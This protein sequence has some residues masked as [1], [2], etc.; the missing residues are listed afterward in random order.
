MTS[1]QWHATPSE[2]FSYIY[3][4]GERIILAGWLLRLFYDCGFEERVSW[5]RLTEK[6][7]TLSC[8]FGLQTKGSGFRSEGIDREGGA[9]LDYFL[10]DLQKKIRE[11]GRRISPA[12]NERS[13]IPKASDILKSEIL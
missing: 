1:C 7:A 8:N 11:E 2:H 4:L 12:R 3:L 13:R 9:D 5:R 10:I 6:I